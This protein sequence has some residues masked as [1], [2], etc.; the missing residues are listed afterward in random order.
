MQDPLG[1]VGQRIDEKY[2]IES[3]VGEGGFAVVYRAQHLIF[4]RPVAIKAFRA[5][6]D[7][8]VEQRER[9][10]N[11]FIQ[12]GALLADLSERSAA[13]IQARDVGTLTTPS[14]DW[15][16]YMVLEWLDGAPLDE[17][18][19]ADNVGFVEDVLAGG[20]LPHGRQGGNRFE[21]SRG[22]AG[23][24]RAAL[25]GFGDGL[26]FEL[27]VIRRAGAMHVLSD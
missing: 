27:G 14:G 24:E 4:K 8:G 22:K 16:P 2:Q 9:L 15:V 3:V 13:I 19:S 17:I 12:E 18:E 25:Q 1:L 23:Q 20:E 6:S 5:M 7:F 10:L 21:I 11:D 26:A